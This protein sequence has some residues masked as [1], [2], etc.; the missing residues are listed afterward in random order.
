MK[1][2]RDK[3]FKQEI[4]KPDGKDDP[5]TIR[6]DENGKLV[7]PSEILKSFG[8]LE[9][10]GDAVLKETADG[11]FLRPARFPLRKLYIEPTTACNYRCK[12]CVRNS[13]DEPTGFME[14]S[15]FR[16]L[17]DDVKE[18]SSLSEMAFWGIGE[19]LLHPQI[20][21]MIGLARNRGLKTELI[22]NG[23]LLDE[24]MSRALMEA[25]LDR[26]IVSID[27]A[28][29]DSYEDIRRGGDFRRVYN[30]LRGLRAQKI[31][32]LRDKPEVGLEYVLMRKNLDQTPLLGLT[33]S[34]TGASFIIF[35]NLLA[36]SETDR[37]E[38]LYSMCMR[39]ACDGNGTECSPE[40]SCREWTLIPILQFPF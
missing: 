35:T 26:L 32:A 39:N 30:N 12:T 15:M 31:A 4:G 5:V 21:E 40:I 25:G 33:T 22:T 36:C 2:Q 9:K 29:A 16:K 24:V 11:L 27:G 19:P 8:F 17:M 14:I 10:G 1:M 37:D 34:L 23:S 18:A 28:L 7:L 13:W 6:V 20:V 3:K 38:V